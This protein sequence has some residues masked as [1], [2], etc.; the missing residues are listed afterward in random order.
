VAVAIDPGTLVT[1]KLASE[2]MD[3]QATIKRQRQRIAA[4]AATL[5]TQQTGMAVMVDLLGALLAADGDA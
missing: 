1:M 5:R 2:L 3:A 4:M